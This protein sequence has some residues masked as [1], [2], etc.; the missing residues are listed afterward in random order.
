MIFGKEKAIYVFVLMALK[1]FDELDSGIEDF[2]GGSQSN[3]GFGTLLKL[4]IIN[5][6]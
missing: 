3:L 4:P 6:L 5:S 2:F 1:K